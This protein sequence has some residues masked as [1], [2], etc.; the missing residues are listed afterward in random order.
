MKDS[1]SATVH[2][3]LYQERR[4]RANPHA[5]FYTVGSQ[6]LSSLAHPLAPCFIAD[7][8]GAFTSYYVWAGARNPNSGP[9]DYTGTLIAG[10][11]EVAL[12]EVRV[13]DAVIYFDG[14]NFTPST[15]SHVAIIVEVHADPLTVSF[16]WQGEP[17][18][19]RVSQDGRAHK[20]YTYNTMTRKVTY[21]PGVKK[22]TPIT[23]PSPA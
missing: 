17:G 10:G 7:C 4:K 5:S 6:R 23:L 2:W 22:R 16:G 12:D 13:G 11:K 3:A 19:C 20:Y 14:P 8:S 9:P 15:G 18:F 21:P 1:R